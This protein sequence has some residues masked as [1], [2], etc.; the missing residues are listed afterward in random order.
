MIDINKWIAS[1]DMAEWMSKNAE[2]S[3]PEQIDCICI[4]PHRTMGEKLAELKKMRINL[5]NDCKLLLNDRIERM[6]TI[7]HTMSTDIGAQK[8]FYRVDIHYMGR[9]V[10]F[11]TDMFFHT[12][13]AAVTAFLTFIEENVRKEQDTKSLYYADIHV[14]TLNTETSQRYQ[15]IEQFVVR[16]DGEIICSKKTMGDDFHCLRLPYPSGT[17]IKSADTAFL[18]PIKGILVNDAEP[19]ERGF[20]ENEYNQWLIYPS[21]RAQEVTKGMGIVHLTNY[22]NPFSDE[23]DYNLPYKQL[24]AAHTGELDK[25]EQWLVELSRIVCRDKTVMNKI[26]TDRRPK[27]TDNLVKQ[28]LAYVKSLDRG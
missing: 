15:C 10:C 20:R 25:Q 19:E 23:C 24:F 7:V 27:A 22:Y 18:P 13:E 3:V 28:R 9:R 5:Q 2:L 14:L 11:P 1:K 8:T 16:H 17:I 26:L 12:K 21:V 4:A 6:E